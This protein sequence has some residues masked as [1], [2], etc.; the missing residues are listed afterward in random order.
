MKSLLTQKTTTQLAQ[1]LLAQKIPNVIKFPLTALLA[2]QLSQLT[3]LVLTPIDLS[4]HTAQQQ[5]TTAQTLADIDPRFLMGQNTNNNASTNIA[6]ADAKLLQGWQLLGTI[7]TD[8]ISLALLQTGTSGKLLWLTQG[9]ILDNG[10]HI[11]AIS[12]QQVAIAT[13]QG[14]K[15]LHLSNSDNPQFLN[16]TT[17]SASLSQLRQQLLTNPIAAMQWLQ[18]NPQWQNGQ[19]TG[20]TLIPQKGHESLLAQLGLQQGDV[21]ISLNGESMQTWMGKLLQLPQVLQGS[22]ARATV[23]RQGKEQ[24]ISISW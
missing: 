14:I 18:I 6:L 16:K 9:Q 2:W 24:E 7:I 15:Y 1:S 22:G 19:L 10:L 13:R 4:I 8:R 3:W 11:Q 21:L 20:V 5:Q 12:P 23:L 17:T